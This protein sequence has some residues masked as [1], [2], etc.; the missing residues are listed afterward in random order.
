MFKGL[1]EDD[2]G[3]YAT[4]AAN[5]MES[6]WGTYCPGMDPSPPPEYS[7]C[8]GDLYSVSWME[9]SD[10]NDMTSE[11]LKKQYQE[12]RLRVSQNYTYS[13]G[14]HVERF[15]ELEL[16]EEAAA[17]FLGEENTGIGPH[18]SLIVNTET[19]GAVKSREWTR[20]GAVLQRDADLMPLKF[21]AAKLAGTPA[22]DEAARELQAEKSRREGLDA[23]VLE[24]VRLVSSDQAAGASTGTLWNVLGAEFLT[25]EPVAAPEGSALVSDWN[26]LRGMVGA[27]GKACGPLDQYGMRHTRAFANLC[28][29]GVK[30]EILEA[31]AERICNDA[32][33]SEDAALL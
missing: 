5:E 8:L 15:G 20:L 30:P 23:S 22:G 13:Q 3:I 33:S 19:K 28:N 27:W 17:R 26:C 18:P 16:D 29:L 2:L 21:K 24:T 10:S 7:T 11:T 1:L 32:A 14:S 6:S 25:S 9:D 31:A 4:T 12:V